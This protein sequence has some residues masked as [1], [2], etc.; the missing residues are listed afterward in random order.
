VIAVACE[1]ISPYKS[2]DTRT[3]VLGGAFS[4]VDGV[5]ILASLGMY[6]TID[7]EMG[8]FAKLL[9]TAGTTERLGDC[10]Y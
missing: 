2:I 9:C 7:H 6:C 5:N 10:T 3:V 4:S 1:A 8:H